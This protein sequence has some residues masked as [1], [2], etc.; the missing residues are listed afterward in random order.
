MAFSRLVAFV[1]TTLLSGGLLFLGF[2]YGFLLFKILGVIT[3]LALAV[4]ITIYI[5]IKRAFRT[6]SK[7]VVDSVQNNISRRHV[8]D[9]EAH[10]QR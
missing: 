6:M 10:E 2:F 5:V 7:R 4:E 9:V 8:R 3:A 1:V